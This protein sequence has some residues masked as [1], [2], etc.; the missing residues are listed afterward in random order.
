MV[1]TLFL[2]IVAGIG[3]L[4]IATRLIEGVEFTGDTQLLLIAGGVLGIINALLKPII[5]FLTL[6]LRIITLGLSSLVV[7]V[8]MVFAI[9]VYFVELDITGLAALLW[10]TLIVWTLSMTLNLFGKGRVTE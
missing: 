5:N 9:E 4:A 7:N 10:T 1:Q 8:L 3:G 2:Q 6:P